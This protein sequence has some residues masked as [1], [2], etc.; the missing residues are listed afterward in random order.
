M[1]SI[2]KTGTAGSDTY[3]LFRQYGTHRATKREK[4][5]E[6]KRGIATL[7][8]MSTGEILPFVILHYFFKDCPEQNIVLAPHG[9]TRGTSKR[10][11]IRTEPSIL[12]I[13]EVCHDKKPKRLYGETFK[14]RG[15]LLES[16][17][18]SSEPRNPKQ[19]Y[20]ARFTTKKTFLVKRT[21]YFSC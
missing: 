7:K 4:D 10:P 9:N 3:V 15:G 13:I 5:V 21:R 14:S 2:T 12:Q 17:S 18:S 6:F 11:Y 16:D 20:N 8:N 19:M 1:L